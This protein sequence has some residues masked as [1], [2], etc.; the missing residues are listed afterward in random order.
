M[1]RTNKQWIARQK[2]QQERQKR[3]L[4]DNVPTP[5]LGWKLIRSFENPLG[6]EYQWFLRGSKWVCDASSGR[7]DPD[8]FRILR[9]ANSGDI[10]W[11]LHMTWFDYKRYRKKARRI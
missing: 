7:E 2:A 1:A 5:E 10:N 6:R 11:V 8:G 3:L 4:W 9:L